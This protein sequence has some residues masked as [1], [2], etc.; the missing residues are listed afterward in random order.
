MPSVS[1]ARLQKPGNIRD[2]PSRGELSNGKTL[3][4]DCFRQNDGLHTLLEK[5]V[6]QTFK[7]ILV[8]L[9]TSVLN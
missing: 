1:D 3:G 9:S 5:E 8:S 6:S 7:G 4:Y 2:D